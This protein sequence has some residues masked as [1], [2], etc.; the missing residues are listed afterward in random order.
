MTLRIQSFLTG[1]IALIAAL[2]L[3]LGNAGAKSASG[4]YQLF[5]PVALEHQHAIQLAS[6]DNF[7]HYAKVASECCNAPNRADDLIAGLPAGTRITPE[8][9]VDIRSINGRTVWLETGNSRAGL[10][11][12]VDGHAGDFASRGVTQAQ[13]P[14]LIF[15]AMQNGRVVGSTGSGRN[16]RSIYEVDFGGT[17][18][19]VAIGV[20]DNGFIVTA[21]PF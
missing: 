16:V 8:N 17:T 18:Q 12:I 5:E 2:L 14:D 11:H 20:G 1:V 21:H 15:D 13:I 9:V 19:R 4:G 3:G 6:L 7:D 10:Q